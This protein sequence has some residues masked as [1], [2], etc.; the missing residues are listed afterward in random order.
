MKILV[1]GATGYVG[2]R[3]VP[4]LLAIGHEIVCL[5]RDPSHISGRGWERV[6]VRRGDALDAGSL[7]PAME[8]VDVA[9]YL[10]H[11]MTHGEGKFEDQDRM[12]AEHFGMAASAAGVRRIIYLGGLGKADET[13][14]P[15]LASRHEVGRILRSSG[16]PV[17]EFRAAVIVGSGSISFEIIRY[18][19]EGLPM[20]FTPRWMQTRCQPIAI[21]NVLDYLTLALQ[22]PGSVGR[23]L[24]IGGPDVLSYREMMLGYASARKLRRILVPLP[25]LTPRL[26]SLFLHMITPI[27]VSISRALIEGMRNEVVVHDHAAEELFPVALIPYHEAVRRALQR[28][29]SGAVETYWTGARTGLQPGVTLKVAEG[30]ILDERRVESAASAAELFA[31]FSG[32][33]GERGWFYGEG[34]W[35]LRGAMDWLVGGVGLRR[36]RRNPD[37]L[38]PGD[39]L[40]FWRVEAVDPGRLVRLRAEM[41][42][43]G[44]AW[45]QFEASDRPGGGALLVQTAFFEPYGFLGL[46]YWNLLYPIHELFFAGMSRAIARRAERA[47][48]KPPRS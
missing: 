47:G 29:Q 21:A 42:V 48:T 44:R 23:T 8:G 33:G 37:E 2:G 12:A 17:T 45:L 27:P 1:T 20:M 34:G 30:M 26:S 36:G 14:S 5:A 28:I 19:I 46:L 41:K 32:I 4:R 43:P 15:H 35:K 38:R 7:L 16:V 6:D 3:L 40:D 18:L 31:T 10:I 9:Y 39:A 11:S 24:E 13:L 22:E 25:V